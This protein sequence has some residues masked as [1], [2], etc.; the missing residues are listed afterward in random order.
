MSL[1]S[2]PELTNRIL[3]ALPEKE[4]KRLLRH[5]K[6]VSLITGE[7]IYAPGEPIRHVYFPLDSIVSIASMT[8][9]G[10]AIELGL[11]GS[12]GM[13]GL[14]VVLG[15]ATTTWRAAVL[16]PG[17]AMRLKAG[18]LESEF[19][20]CGPL[21]K[22]LLRHSHATVIEV[23]QTAVC[24]TLHRVD[25]RLCHRLLLTHDRVGSSEFTLTHEGL[26]HM[27]GAR[28]AGVSEAAARLRGMGLISYSRGKLRINDRQGLESCTCECYRVIKQEVDRL[29]GDRK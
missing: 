19:D 5:L 14:P 26:A 10:A 2:H 4:R 8:A 20:A 13:V 24:N 23:S 3:A 9:D 11:I 28:R 16:V 25:Q 22:L 18:V 1:T 6:A 27:I 12:E 17:A 15:V 7:V 21:L 29:Y